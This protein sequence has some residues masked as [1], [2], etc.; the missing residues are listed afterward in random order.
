MKSAAWTGGRRSTRTSATT[1]PAIATSD[2]ATTRRPATSIGQHDRE[3]RDDQVKEAVVR[4]IVELIG[5]VLGRGRILQTPRDVA[6]G[7]VLRVVDAGQQLGHEQATDHQRDARPVEGRQPLRAQRQVIDPAR[8]QRPCAHR[9]DPRAAFAAQLVVTGGLE[10]PAQLAARWALMPPVYRMQAAPGQGD[11]PKPLHGRGDREDAP[12]TEATQHAIEPYPRGAR[13]SGRRLRVRG[14]RDAGGMR[15]P[16][17]G[18]LREV[19]SR[20]ERHAERHAERG[21]RRPGPFCGGRHPVHRR[22][23]GGV[24]DEL[25]EHAHRPLEHAEAQISAGPDG[26]PDGTDNVIKQNLKDARTDFDDIS[27][28]CSQ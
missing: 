6:E 23:T 9:S 8:G 4:E 7:Q 27:R 14:V 10:S 18:R 15:Q 16:A 11:L 1:A 25:Q 28:Y 21:D 19:P 22:A 17:Q 12:G 3:P 5:L 20:H 24:R 2:A 13:R 26:P